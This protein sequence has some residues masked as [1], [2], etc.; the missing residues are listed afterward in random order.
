MSR[1]KILLTGANGFLGKSII[2]QLKRDFE[3][4]TCSR[5]DADIS[6]DIGQKFSFPDELVVDAV[7]HAA[8]KA[9]AVPKT[10][11]E[12]ELFF[13]IN[14]EGTKNICSALEQLKALPKAFIFISSVSVYGVDQGDMIAEDHPLLGES[15]YARSKILAENWLKKWSADNGVKLSILRLPLVAGPNPPG[16]LGAMINGIQTG[17]YL[18]IGNAKAL[19][20]VVWAED[21][22]NILPELIRCGGVFNLTDG[23][24]PSFAELEDAI[25]AALNKQRPKKIPLLMARCLGKVGDLLGSWSPV[26]SDK[27][28]KITSSLTFND[29]FARSRVNWNPTKVLDKIS[30][31]LKR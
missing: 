23:Y 8:G 2:K 21:I 30:D 19:K 4:I 13:R 15:P 31:I 20:S 14:F 27:I 16:N 25:S 12:K 26:N 7:F 17:R 18:S 6:I 5:K 22:A 24:H 28:R 29:S 1:D 9:H 11:E 3:V 10:E